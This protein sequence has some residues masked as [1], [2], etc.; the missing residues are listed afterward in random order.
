MV[1]APF[2]YMK[3]TIH[4]EGNIPNS[5]FEYMKL[6]NIKIPSMITSQTDFHTNKQFSTLKKHN[7]KF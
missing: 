2:L 3:R 1:F 6:Q 4:N 7:D 5:N